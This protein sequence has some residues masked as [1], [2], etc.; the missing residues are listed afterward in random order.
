MRHLEILFVDFGVTC[1]LMFKNHYRL[2]ICKEFQ[3]ELE[4]QFPEQ[5]FDVVS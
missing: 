2:Y 5:F 4:P 1:G 3:L